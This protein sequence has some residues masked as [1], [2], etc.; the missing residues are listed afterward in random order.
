MP[1]PRS[2]P[3]SSAA[4]TRRMADRME[5]G[6]KLGRY[7]IEGAMGEGG[8]G[9]V[10]RARDARLGRKVALKVLFTSEDDPES[11]ERAKR[12][13]REAKLGGGA[14]SP[15]RGRRSSTS[16]RRARSRSW[17]WSWSTGRSLRAFVA[18]REGSPTSPPAALALDI[19]V[20]ARRR[21]RQEAHPPRH[22]ARERD[23]PRRR[24][25]Q[26]ARLRPRPPR[27]APLARR[28]ERS[29]PAPVH[30]DSTT[31]ARSPRRG[32]RRSRRGHAHR[33][34]AVHGAGADPNPR[35]STRAA[36][37][38]RGG[39]SRTSCSPAAAV[40]GRWASA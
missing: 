6:S 9:A 22:Q 33:Y 34:A 36:T 4:P 7:T 17:R 8:M 14:R 16:A 37:S 38:S 15:Q 32:R 11:V 35:R 29:R 1:P 40:D 18:S 24:A 5:V 28:V 26:G 10:Y 19:A 21:A 13:L 23:D 39:S 2:E 20:R 27:R 25:G 12:F 3:P 31:T 30:S